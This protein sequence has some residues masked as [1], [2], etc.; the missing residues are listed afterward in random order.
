M[1][2][3]VLA[4]AAVMALALVLRLTFVT[5][6]VH[7]DDLEYA[8]AAHQFA[9]SG[10]HLTAT[11]H[12]KSGAQA[13]R[14]R[15]TMYVPVGVLYRLF[16]VSDVTT[17]AWPLLC[18]LLTVVLVYCVTALLANESSAL[19]AAFVWAVLPV[20]IA[21]ATSLLPDGP[22]AM[23]STAA[24]L[25]FL[26][27]DRSDGRRAVAYYAGCACCFT[28]AVLAKQ[29]GLIPSLFF[30]A[31]LAYTRRLGWRLLGVA[32]AFVCVTAALFIY[33]YRF[34]GGMWTGLG[35]YTW[36]GAETLVRTATDWYH[37]VSRAED[38][39][40]FLP[41]FIVAA[42]GA[43]ALRLPGAAVAFLWL[44]TTFFYM[45][46]G[47]RNPASYAPWDDLRSRHLTFVIVP[48]AVLSGIY[49]G[50]SVT[51]R[52]ARWIVTA[53]AAVVAGSVWYLAHNL[54]TLPTWV[55]GDPEKWR[56]FVTVSA[57][58]AAV[59]IFGSFASPLFVIG[60]RGRVRAVAVTLL[61]VGLG[62]A[63]LHP[64]LQAVT[65]YR[66]PWVENTREA[67]KFLRTRTDYQWLAQT[68]QLAGRLEYESGY[69]R[70][71]PSAPAELAQIG[72]A[73]VITDTFFERPR[74]DLGGAPLT[75]PA[76]LTAPPP[77]WWPIAA[78][79][80]VK[81]H[82][83]RVYRVLAGADA[84]RE[85]AAAR[86]EATRMPGPE[87]ERRLAG[88]EVN[89]GRHCAAAFRSLRD[90]ADAGS[91]DSAPGLRSVLTA[92]YA[93]R[94]E[95]AGPPLLENGDFSEALSGWYQP[96]GPGEFRVVPEGEDGPRH[97]QVHVADAGLHVVLLQGIEIKPDTPY[98]YE[99]EVKSTG[100]IVTLYWESDVGRF[101]SER[102]F[103]NWTRV[104]SILVTPHWDGKPRKA[105]FHPFLTKG[106]GDVSIRNVRLA[107]LRPE[108]D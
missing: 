71:V 66:T 75:L 16:G 3:K 26:I 105:D 9:T 1:L 83:M 34:S 20:D 93:A 63:T 69:T 41:L 28:A 107:E 30:F 2:H 73:Y 50:Q 90:A 84:E 102:A 62:L 7:S 29:T 74:A 85:L 88:A 95:I 55:V 54:P 65:A 27:A 97:L 25:L 108:I 12:D 37:F 21:L 14:G 4:L 104:Q 52:A 38:F 60:S 31:Y 61:L 78:F 45:E 101:Q 94:P 64:T 100:P 91:A 92:C 17:L 49:L 77:T 22:L 81:G 33:H 98:V 103:P 23:F 44:A 10:F 42:S 70:R 8:V 59:A 96:H 19:F 67:V 53:A 87:A 68:D 46:L 43:L 32:T 72:S 99:M 18:S 13:G 86:L 24:V 89:A 47:S 36:P 56:P 15:L 80:R 40:P 58:A 51:A 11:S 35:S 39:F 79:G 5:G 82:E 57:L 106:I 76:Y 48:C 6:M